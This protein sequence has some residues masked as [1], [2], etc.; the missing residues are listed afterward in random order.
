MA[1]HAN[2][3]IAMMM[4]HFLSDIHKYEFYLEFESILLMGEEKVEGEELGG[5]IEDTLAIEG[6]GFDLEGGCF[7]SMCI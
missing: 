1:F 4:T 2:T 6:I 3:V 7:L 5:G